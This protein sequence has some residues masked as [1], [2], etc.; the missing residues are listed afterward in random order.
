MKLTASFSIRQFAFA[1][2]VGL[3]FLVSLIGGF[4]AYQ[5]RAVTHSLEQH[6][7]DAARTELNASFERLRARWKNRRA[8]WPAGTRPDNSW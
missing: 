3:L 1:F 2:I 4:A 7:L 6:S 8:V 5:T